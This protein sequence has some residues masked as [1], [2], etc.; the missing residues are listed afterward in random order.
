MTLL[1]PLVALLERDHPGTPLVVSAFTATGLAAARKL[2]PDHRVTALPLD[3]SFVVRRFLRHFDPRL[4]I[5][6][7]SEFW[8]NLIGCA[9]ARGVPVALVNG[10]MS[11]K[12]YRAHSRA[13]LIPHV[14]AKLDLFAVQTRR[15]RGAPAHRSACRAGAHQRH[16][17]HEIRPGAAGA[18]R[19]DARALRS[20]LG[21]ADGDVV[22]IGGSLHERE[23]EA[24]LDAFARARAAIEPCARSSSCRVIRP[25]PL[26]IEQ[27]ARRAGTARSARPPSTQAPAARRDGPAF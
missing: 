5:V 3:F 19:G 14:L 12:S 25:L 17:Q 18:S 4:M 8:P 21:Y 20:A 22:I 13:R 27:H 1:R 7:E 16:R 9:R 6:V 11:A 23:D 15:A 26:P 24:L 2:Y 10:K